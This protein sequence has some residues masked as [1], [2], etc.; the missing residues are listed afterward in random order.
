MG[1]SP[2]V[3]REIGIDERWYF[4]QFRQLNFAKM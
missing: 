4:R 3:V 2:D 1:L